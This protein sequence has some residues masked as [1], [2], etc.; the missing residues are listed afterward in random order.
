ML[1]PSPPAPGSPRINWGP[2]CTDLVLFLH[3]SPLDLY[4]WLYLLNVRPEAAAALFTAF[5]PVPGTEEALNKYLLHERKKNSVGFW[6]G[7][8]PTHR[9]LPTREQRRS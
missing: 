4:L 8:A 3:G 1:S 2:L 6:F 7:Q 9:K 5:S